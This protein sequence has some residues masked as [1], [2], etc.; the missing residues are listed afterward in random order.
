MASWDD[1]DR[2]ATALP[3]VERAADT[4]GSKWVVRKKH[5]AWERQLRARDLEELGGEAPEGEL[6]AVMVAD[7]NE[8][9]GLIGSNPDVFFT[10]PHF[11]N[12]PAVLVRLERIQL[13]QLGEI[14]TDAWLAR[15]PKRLA[16]SFLAE[17]P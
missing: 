14:L 13:D 5:F 7:L 1:V 9:R 3:E 17:H 6:L 8:K 15:A 12:Y 4:W 10:M 2:L 16:A 11:A